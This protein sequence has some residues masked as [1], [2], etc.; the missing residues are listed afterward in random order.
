[1]GGMIDFLKI[2]LTVQLFWSFGITIL[3]STIPSAQLP[4]ISLFTDAANSDTL[5]TLGTEIQGNLK[6]QLDLP[7]VDFGSLVFYSGN[8][9]IDLALNF[10]FAIPEL[11][12][13]LMSGVFIF[14]PID[15]TLQFWVKTFA[16]TL[17][18]AL[19]FLGLI[20]FLTTMRSGGA[21]VA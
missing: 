14:A 3:V 19:Y 4:Y 16:F 10:F 11:S 13:L 9:V 5:S 2:V 8:L 18:A 17:I 12:T 15:I 7:I 1:M 20:N 6:S 21:N